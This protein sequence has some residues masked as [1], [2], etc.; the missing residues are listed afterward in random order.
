M[1]PTVGTESV[2]LEAS[3]AAIAATQPIIVNHERARLLVDPKPLGVETNLFMTFLMV[4]NHR[5]WFFKGL[6]HPETHV[7]EKGRE[8]RKVQ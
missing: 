8:R 4:A 2:D 5:C 1:L 6:L 7:C 3:Q